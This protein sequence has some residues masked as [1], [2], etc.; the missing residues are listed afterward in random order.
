MEVES[1]QKAVW[2]DQF[3]GKHSN[4]EGLT[5]KDSTHIC[6]ATIDLELL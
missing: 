4:W 3:P 6:A 1:V 5:N 2:T